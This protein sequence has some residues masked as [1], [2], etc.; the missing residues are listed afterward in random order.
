MQAL[1]REAERAKEKGYFLVLHTPIPQIK[2][3]N[4]QHY[5]KKELNCDTTGSCAYI[6]KKP[7]WFASKMKRL[8]TICDREWAEDYEVLL[9]QG[10]KR[11][12]GDF[13][14]KL[15]KEF[16]ENVFVWDLDNLLCPEAGGQRLC[17]TH[18]DHGRLYNDFAGHLSLYAN[19]KLSS[20]FIDFFE[21]EGLIAT[22]KTN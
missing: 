22:S 9:N 15:Q 2:T 4:Q 1:R 19:F 8:R 16:P 6:C 12:V 11:A 7:D 10:R 21:R 5:L 14:E 18:D 20:E 3:L 13:L 17:S